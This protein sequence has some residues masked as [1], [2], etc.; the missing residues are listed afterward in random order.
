MKKFVCI[1]RGKNV[2][3]EREEEVYRGEA[4]TQS[5]WEI[6]FVLARGRG[7]VSVFKIVSRNLTCVLRYTCRE[8]NLRSYDKAGKIL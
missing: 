5:P 6:G 8:N 2:Y 7:R 1:E 3:V 4:P